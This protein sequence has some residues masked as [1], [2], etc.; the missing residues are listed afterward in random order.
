M[1][2]AMASS[3]IRYLR[4]RLAADV[5]MVDHHHHDDDDD[6]VNKRHRFPTFVSPYELPTGGKGGGIRGGGGGNGNG[7]GGGGMSIPLVYC[8]QTASQRP[9]TSIEDYI[10]RVSMPCHANTHTVSGSF[11]F[12]LRPE[13]SCVD[14]AFSFGMN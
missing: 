2:T 1:T 6:G 3:D 9:V 10:R 8:D 11:H 13:A 7:N 5:V 14:R 4:A 12:F